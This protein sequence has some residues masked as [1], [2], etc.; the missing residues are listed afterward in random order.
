[1][2]KQCW[3]QGSSKEGNCAGVDATGRGGTAR[4]GLPSKGPAMA[5]GGGTSRA[6]AP[7]LGEPGRDLPPASVGA[8]PGARQLS[9]SISS[10][11]ALQGRRSARP[12]PRSHPAPRS[13][14]HSPTPRVRCALPPSA[15]QA[16]G[17]S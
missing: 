10:L 5:L 15:P 11:S 13:R 17:G 6:A 14:A 9:T 4:D 8:G 1:M 7:G 3:A 16:L 2:E 12:G